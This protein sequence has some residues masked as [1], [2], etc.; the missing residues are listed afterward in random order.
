MPFFTVVDER[1]MSGR[2]AVDERSMGFY[3][4]LDTSHLL[5]YSCLGW[6]TNASGS[7]SGTFGDSGD[8]RE[9]AENPSG[10]HMGNRCLRNYLRNMGG[11]I[12]GRDPDKY[13]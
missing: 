12:D 5:L 6:G 1:S 10:T 3:S 8:A 9:I 13:P 2:R 11:P 4:T 7:G